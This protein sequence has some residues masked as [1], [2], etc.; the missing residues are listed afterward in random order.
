[1]YPAGAGEE[2]LRTRRPR[3]F[4]SVPWMW[5]IMVMHSCLRNCLVRVSSQTCLQLLHC[6]RTDKQ[7]S[8]KHR[9]P[10]GAAPA[11]RRRV[12]RGAV[13][14]AARRRARAA[15]RGAQGP[16]GRRAR[17]RVARGRAGRAGQPGRGPPAHL[18]PGRRRR[19]GEAAQGLAWP[20]Y[21]D[22]SSALVSQVM[23]GCPACRKSA[24]RG[25]CQS[26]VRS[27]VRQ[28]VLTGLGQHEV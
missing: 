2:P 3:S 21:A 16:C 23:C 25:A 22:N 4:S 5:V 8:Q 10:C 9:T 20:C 14:A 18:A 15:R 17:D 24:H 11:P 1:M 6:H 19:A 13:A 12:R 26:F 7:N 28:P 27:G